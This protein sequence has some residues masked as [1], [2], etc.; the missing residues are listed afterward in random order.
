[1]LLRESNTFSVFSGTSGSSFL[2][3]VPIN[4]KTSASYISFSF[5]CANLVIKGCFINSE[6]LGLLSGSI[7]KH[8]LTKSTNSSVFVYINNFFNFWGSASNFFH[9]FPWLQIPIRWFTLYQFHTCYSQRPNISLCV[10]F[11][12]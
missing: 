4:S 1:M 9:N 7:S 8:N 2:L 6:A 5:P 12:I 11:F 3:F 10:I